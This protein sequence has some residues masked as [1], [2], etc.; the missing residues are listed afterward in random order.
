MNNNLVDL[1]NI[2]NLRFQIGELSK[3]TGVSTRQL[4]YWEQ[5]EFISANQRE[6]DQDARVF[7]FR[8]YIK[9]ALIK[10]YLDEGYKL[11]VANEKS[12][13]TIDDAEWFHHFFADSFNGIEMVDGKR[14]VNLGFFDQ[15][16]SQVLYGFNEDGQ[17]SYRV[18]PVA[19]K[20]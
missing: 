10:H 8:M 6:A 15:E 7:S 4:R 16:K 9:V 11:G 2:P 14:S 18:K 12:K 5:K 3:M 1:V 20:D 17:V 19:K 13:A